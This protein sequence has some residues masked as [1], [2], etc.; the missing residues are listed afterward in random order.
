MVLVLVEEPGASG[1]AGTPSF[2]TFDPDFLHHRTA[3]TVA[4]VAGLTEAGE[5]ALMRMGIDEVLDHKDVT[6]SALARALNRVRMRQMVRSDANQARVVAE[7]LLDR[8]PLAVVFVRTSGHIMYANTRACDIL[9]A[10][11]GLVRSASNTIGAV[12]DEEHRALLEAIR[13]VATG[14][15]DPEGALSITALDA[16]DPIS[17]IVVPAGPNAQGAALF[18]SDPEAT[19]AIDEARL[20]ALYDLTR[21]EARILAR[22]SAGLTLEEI[23][24]E[25][26]QKA[27][28]VRG[29]L[30]S[31]FRKTGARRQSEAI[32]VVLSGPAVIVP[33]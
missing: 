21:S 4:V 20:A 23:A 27:A 26:G 6:P 13:S 2:G 16:G 12:R 8:M 19:I 33:D 32:K 3:E 28:T 1:G 17:V 7:S 30:K 18:L 25:R 22:L 14:D 29:Q 10:G 9:D 5:A 24:A 31:I 15:A 11:R